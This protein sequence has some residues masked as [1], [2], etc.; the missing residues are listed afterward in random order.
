MNFIDCS[1]DEESEKACLDFSEFRLEMPSIIADIL[2]QVSVSE[3]VF[4][5]RPEDLL[6]SKT[7]KPSSIRSTIYVI[8]PEG[9]EVLLTVRIG[10]TLISTVTDPS[11]KGEI[12]DE[13]FVDFSRTK[14]HLFS[15]ATGE[16]IV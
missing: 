15:K 7:P 3:L 12:G 16:I 11:F 6:I 5:I 10:K 8:E 9:S 13:V 2:K 1:L 14:F 4:G